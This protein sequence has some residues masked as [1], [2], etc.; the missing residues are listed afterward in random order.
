[1][2]IS[3][4]EFNSEKIPVFMSYPQADA[5]FFDNMCAEFKVTRVY[6]EDIYRSNP[7]HNIEALFHLSGNLSQQIIKSEFWRLGLCEEY[8]C[9]DSDMVF[10]RPFR[11]RDLRAEDGNLL[12][13]MHTGQDLLDAAASR[14]LNDILR[15]FYADSD[16]IKKWFGR[17]GQDYD[18]GPSPFLWSAKVW[19]CLDKDFLEPKGLTLTD[20]IKQ[21]GS[22]VRWYGETLLASKVIPLH[23]IGPLAKFYHYEWQYRDEKKGRFTIPDTQSHIGKVLQ[24]N[25]DKSL[26]PAFSKKSFP[27]RLW[28]TI[29]ET[30]RGR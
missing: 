29:R 19:R 26:E 30:I 4:R 27:S 23:P 14:G 6:D 20:V 16:R 5:E 8:L 3:L 28:R 21:F 24:S 13:V 17:T 7:R 15:D 22:E 1:M 18:F 11:A 10:T 9:V 2:L 12:T 25:W